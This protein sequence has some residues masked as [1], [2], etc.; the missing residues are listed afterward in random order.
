MPRPDKGYW[1]NWF[2]RRAFLPANSS[3]NPSDKSPPQQALIFQIFTQTNKTNKHLSK[4]LPG[5]GMDISGEAGIFK[6]T[7]FYSFFI[8]PLPGASPEGDQGYGPG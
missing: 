3:G 5:N 2:C 8:R 1:V 7:P 6:I 4:L